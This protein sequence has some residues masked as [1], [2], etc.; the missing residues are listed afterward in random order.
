M[1]KKYDL[2][3]D[4][5]MYTGDILSEGSFHNGAVTAFE[6]LGDIEL[7]LNTNRAPDMVLTSK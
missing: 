6:S 2:S 7:D 1:D 5:C 3:Y 4:N